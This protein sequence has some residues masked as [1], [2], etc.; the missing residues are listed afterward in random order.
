M[1]ATIVLTHGMPSYFFRTFSSAGADFAS[2]VARK[3]LKTRKLS[4]LASRIA[5]AVVVV[6]GSGM[7]S[8]ELNIGP[9]LVHQVVWVIVVSLPPAPA[10]R[11]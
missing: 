5:N 1:S 8:I 6:Q 11:P 4:A 3:W 2:S 7:P 9:Y 10:R